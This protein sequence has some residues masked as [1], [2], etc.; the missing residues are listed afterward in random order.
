M[1]EHG[2]GQSNL[3]YLLQAG[4]LLSQSLGSSFAIAF[5]LT[6]LARGLQGLEASL[7]SSRITGKA[8]HALISHLLAAGRHLDNDVS[9]SPLMALTN[10]RIIP[11]E[12]HLS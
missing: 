12:G 2:L 7:E 10:G 6:S 11:G 8:Q 5:A 4:G 1:Q 9:A 3:S